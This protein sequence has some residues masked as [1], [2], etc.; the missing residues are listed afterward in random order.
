MVVVLVVAAAAG[1]AQTN[2]NGFL[3]GGN[4]KL[5]YCGAQDQ[6]YTY[7]MFDV[8]ALWIVKVCHRYH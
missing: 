8:C 4:N 3:T 2:H 1:F 7:T 6:Y 5:L